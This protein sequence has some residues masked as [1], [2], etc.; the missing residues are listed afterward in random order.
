[1]KTCLGLGERAGIE[2]YQL[3]AQYISRLP[4]PDMDAAEQEAIGGLAMAITEQA[5]ARYDL[6][7]RARHRIESDLG[8]PSKRL[9]QKLTAWWE[10]DFPSFR[11][12]IKKV[13]TRDIPLRERDEWDVWLANRRAEHD[14]RTAEIVRLETGLNARVYVLF[15]LTPAEIQTIEEITKYRYGEV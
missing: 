6:H 4:V 5:R 14:Q 9:N 10:L 1:M 8:V 2:R 3:F 11:A 13:F 15:D 7:R 12:E